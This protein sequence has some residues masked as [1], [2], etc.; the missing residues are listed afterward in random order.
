MRTSMKRLCS[1]LVT[2]LVISLG[3]APAR[4]QKVATVLIDAEFSHPTSTSA[5]AIELGARMAAREIEQS[6]LL[7]D[8]RLEIR[9]SDNRGVSAIGVDNFLDAAKDPSVIA[10]MGGKFSP[11]QIEVVPYA[12][13]EKLILLDP[14]GSADGIVDNGYRPNWAFR[15]SLKDEWASQAFVQTAKKLG[16]RQIGVILPNTA[17]GRSTQTALAA[18][19][20]TSALRIVGERWYNWGETSLIQRYQDLI[21]DGAEIIVLVANEIEG[22]ILVREVA[23][24]PENQRRPILSHWGVTGGNFEKLAPQVS[25]LDFRVVQTFSFHK[26]RT[27]KAKAF[28]RDVM[29]ATGKSAIGE[30]DSPAGIAHAYDLTWMVGKAIAKAGSTDRDKIRDALETLGPHEGVVRNYPKPF[31]ADSHEALS[32][33]EVFFARFRAENGLVPED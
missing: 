8:I 15:L 7:G 26:P 24:V 25:G 14:W 17:W 1:L 4:A 11:V 32:K 31:S 16:A 19:A 23:Q 28:L 20:R 21:A 12:H 2:A 3:G 27:E 10:V 18:Q 30:I 6:G 9:T 22:S 33:D 5:Q 29:A 13:S